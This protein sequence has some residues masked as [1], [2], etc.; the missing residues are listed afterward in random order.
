MWKLNQLGSVK[1]SK[2]FKMELGKT[3][4]G[5]AMVLLLFMIL[6]KILLLKQIKDLER[7]ILGR[8]FILLH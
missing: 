4:F 3:N 1:D 7:N 5:T 8:E 6:N 2:K